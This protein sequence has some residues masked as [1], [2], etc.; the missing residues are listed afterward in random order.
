MGFVVK[1]IK[2]VVK[3]VGQVIGKVVKV[4]GG[5]F[6]FAVG[7]KGK[8]SDAQNTLTKQIDP[9]APRKII[10]GKTAAPLDIR[11]WE[12]HG[13]DGKLYDEVI[14]LAAHK[15]NAIAELYVEDKLAINAA[16][17]PQGDFI[18]VLTR[19]HKLGAD[20]QTGLA[21]GGGSQWT[22]ATCTM[23]GIAYIVLKWV[24]DEKKLPSGIPNRYTQV[25]EGMPV[26]DPRRDSTVPGGSGSHR[27]DDQNT[28][29]YSTLD[30]NGQPIG[31]NNALQ[32]LA[33][34]IGWTSEVKDAGGTVTGRALT[35]GRGVLPE[36]INLAT[37]I[38]GANNCEVAGYYTDIVLST[39]DD[40]TS[41]ENA[42]TAS[43]LIGRLIDPG[44]LWSYY[45][46]VDD[47]A[48][49][50]VELTDADVLDGTGL[51]WDEF[52]GMSEQFTQVAGKFVN[53]SSTVLYQPYF[54]PMVRDA[55]YENNLGRKVRKT[56]D[57]RQ[58]LDGVLAQR[59]ARLEL[60]SGQYQGELRGNFNYKALQAQAYSIVRYT[61]ERFGW[62]KLFRVWRHEISAE[63]GVSMLLKETHSSVWAAGTVQYP[64]APRTGIKYDPRT[65]YTVSGL[66]AYQ[67]PVTAP[68]GS[69]Q[70]AIRV[71]W[72]TPPAQVRRTEIRHKLSG[73]SS[74][75]SSGLLDKDTTE[76]VIQSLLSGGN[77]DIEARHVSV[78]EIPGPWAVISSFANGTTGNV[79]YA[80]IQ[81]AGG[82][83]VWA[84]VSG[85]GKPTDNADVTANNISSGIANESPWAK[86][87]SQFYIDANNKLISV[88]AGATD[89]LGLTEVMGS[90]LVTI[91]GNSVTKGNTSGWDSLVASKKL[92]GSV[93]V[94]AVVNAAL[95][96]AMVGL[97]D[98][99]NTSAPSFGRMKYALYVENDKYK[100]FENGGHLA[101]LGS[102]SVGDIVEVEYLQDKVK[103]WI[104]GDP[105][106]TTGVATDQKLRAEVAVHD[107]DVTPFKNI[108]FTPSADD[109]KI[110]SVEQGATVGAE[111]GVNTSGFGAL[112]G[113][114]S[115]DFATN[116]VSNR[117]ADYVTET[118]TR[119]WAGESGADVTGGK[120]AAGISNESPWAKSNSQPY[121]DAN[122]K[123][124]SVAAGATDD[125]G[126]VEVSGTLL[127]T[128]RVTIN[129][130]QVSRVNGGGWD[131]LVAGHY[132]AGSV[133]VRAVVNALGGMA[134]V[135]LQDGLN[136][137]QQSYQRLNY[138]LY[139]N[140]DHYEIWESGVQIGQVG[141]A[142][143]VGDVLEVE[144][145]QD[146]VIYYI[147]GDDVRTVENVAAGRKFRAGVAV[148]SGSF[149][150]FKNIS[151][152]PTADD[153]KILGVADQATN[154][155]IPDTRNDDQP[156]SW[157][158]TNYPM[159]RIVEFKD[160][161]YLGV[162]GYG[163]SGF[164]GS[165]ETTVDFINES[166]GKVKQTYTIGIVTGIIGKVYRR[167]ST[168]ESTWG[169]WQKD[170]SEFTKPAF[171]AD[172]LKG[173][174]IDIATDLE[175]RTPEG[176]ASGISNESPW[177]K[178]TSQPYIDANNK[179]I[180]IAEGATDDLALKVIFG[181]PANATIK[182]NYYVYS[183]PGSWETLLGSDFTT[184]SVKVRA[185]MKEAGTYNFFGLSDG[186]STD[187]TAFVRL[188]YSIYAAG[189]NYNIWEKG[190]SVYTVPG[191]TPA[192]GDIIEIEYLQDRVIYYINGDDVYTSY[193]SVAPGKKFRLGIA[194]TS[195]G[196]FHKINI[197][198]TSDDEKLKSLAGT[199]PQ[200]HGWY[201]TGKVVA[202]GATDHISTSSNSLKRI[203]NTI[204]ANMYSILSNAKLV[205]G[206]KITGK[207]GGQLGWWGGCIGLTALNTWP[208]YDHE[209]LSADYGI[210][211]YPQSSGSGEINFKRGST[212]VAT[213]VNGQS[214]AAMK[215]W[216]G[217]VRYDGK[218]IVWFLRH[219]D[220]TTHSFEEKIGPD[221]EFRACVSVGQEPGT[222]VEGLSFVP[223][224]EGSVAE[225]LTTLITNSWSALRSYGNTVRNTSVTHGYQDDHSPYSYSKGAVIEA[226]LTGNLQMI[227]LMDDLGLVSNSGSSVSGI[228]I[229]NG[230]I[231]HFYR[232]SNG[233]YTSTTIGNVTT[234]P[235]GGKWR[236][237]YDGRTSRVLY[238]G[239]LVDEQATY[240]AG[241]VYAR[242]KMYVALD[243][244][245]NILFAPHPNLNW[246]H[247]GGSGK[248]QDNAD[249]TASNI[250]SGI[251]NES[252]WAKSNSQPYIDANNK[253]TGVETS[254]D[255]TKTVSGPTE[256]ILNYDS[257]GNLTTSLPASTGPL[258]K[259]TPAGGA[260]YT[261][262][263]TWAVSV[264]A[265]TFAGAAPSISGAG[266]GNLYINSNMT[267]NEAT[268]SVTPTFG[269]KTYPSFSV[270]VK[271]VTAT[272][273]QSGGTGGAGTF[274][275]DTTLNSFSTSTPVAVSDVLPVATG[276]SSTSVTLTAANLELWGQASSPAGT[277]NCAFKW[278][279]RVPGGTFADFGTVVNSDPDPTVEYD[280]EFGG[281][282]AWQS[283]RVTCN[284]V[285]T[286]LSANTNY[287]FRL[288]AYNTTS[289]KVI[290]IIGEASAQG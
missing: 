256:I 87:N 228:F 69:K 241:P 199:N 216:T 73:T 275:K 214:L 106:T 121:I 33:Y 162:P 247:L 230:D 158:R 11:Y 5:I 209:Y 42:I 34:L 28:W 250:A 180:G 257:Q 16:G 170:Y 100:I 49:I 82:T 108:S 208:N 128:N 84:N 213:P 194:P 127:N 202:A 268:L 94:R 91:N 102:A 196:A 253:L 90:G 56:L 282:N 262:G 48:N 269:G 25:V 21:V 183:G 169:A 68:D 18:G 236:C 206:A 220:G 38:T 134:M 235:L 136:T 189:G 232:L 124:I 17:A 191:I 86:S 289:T 37:F 122:N 239:A 287:E 244:I 35:C 222:T 98:G 110:L 177:A 270:K 107:P 278:Q 67:H 237:E 111:Y 223:H 238:N 173:N 186:V 75:T 163:A 147:N 137:T 85:A 240:A 22:A 70:D 113:K 9:E 185:V 146:K 165:L 203:S 60:N 140:S 114:G 267:S 227:G 201:P 2:A 188:N 43:G 288:M 141:G 99:V 259:L 221:K 80:A 271:R 6:G 210:F 74:W 8:Q 217:E 26:Y 1:G 24:P 23:D 88:A 284:Q 115:V 224:G 45:A 133:K 174:A 266:S 192:V 166:G 55:V 104:N 30:G 78:N 211:F 150:P 151:F 252:P 105:Y 258:F 62:V 179:L 175:Y 120:I 145:L 58:V 168:S 119:K 218:K 116:E 273:S 7:G 219:I 154:D 65:E 132:L 135:G 193:N 54:Y 64:E 281:Y 129:G 59:L 160:G 32:A 93:K 197:T 63:D 4:I 20:G 161:Y 164:Y 226:A 149:T 171:G 190:S 118:V 29:S 277:W 138:P 254:A 251:S 76:I 53:P 272:A 274:A 101:T 52:K 157:Y 13:S 19:S 41:N 39:E 187:P 44:G 283:G 200:D 212:T 195:V 57:F 156:P 172:L 79:N 148:N 176:I 231:S 15:V 249:V 153:G 159:R 47:T 71:V 152:T 260:S 198:P 207:V 125:L 181:A 89:D 50:A 264:A 12:V 27:I 184:G 255:V 143:A 279:W 61:S 14:A 95:T 66:T 286:G 109:G 248:P 3:G 204:S 139:L 242:V 10:F 117:F 167:V 36:D 46:N 103:Y 225:N 243:E 77:Y 123:L 205:G 51:S 245:N 280:A 144:Y 126:L 40:H 72:A 246:A 285:K 261:S 131:S 96:Y 92:A 83:A 130:N 265:G 234:Y 263:V 142:A 155:R 233:A 276:P 290:S 112:A 178:S 182:G 81:A 229:V 215:D 97:G 31:R